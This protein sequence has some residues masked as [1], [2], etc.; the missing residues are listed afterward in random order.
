M[1]EFVSI[2][3]S[4][5]VSLLA[6]RNPAPLPL[7][8][9]APQV[10]GEPRHIPALDG[11]RGIAVLLVLWCHAIGADL[12]T[13]IASPLDRFA[14][15]S[16]RLA[17]SGV[18]LFFVLSG[19]LITGILCDAKGRDHYFRNFY[20]RR[21][22]R[23]FPLYYACLALFLVVIPMLAPA[24]A[25]RFGQPNT[26]QAW[27]WAYLSN[28]SQPFALYLGQPAHHVLS[29]T[30][31]LAVEEQFYLVWPAVVFFLDRRALLRVCGW[32][33]VFSF[34]MRLALWMTLERPDCWQI[35]TDITPC[36]L[37]VLAAG[38]AIA[39]IARGPGGIRGLIKPAKIVGPLAA[40]ILMA[41][42]G[43]MAKLGYRGGLITT[44]GYVLFGGTLYAAMY[45]SLLVWAV[46]QRIQHRRPSVFLR[47]APHVRQ[48]Q[49]RRLP[50]AHAGD[51]A[52]GRVCDA[53]RCAANR[54]HLAAERR[55]LLRDQLNRNA[56]AGMVELERI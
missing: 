30:W 34:G 52:A 43:L 39:L 44:P 24:L 25:Q 36:R 49:L 47:R 15:T 56:G 2:P 41:M 18:D 7:E 37:D 27:Y 38:A 51:H 53:T 11:V 23:I 33:F 22:V 45:G 13:N 21:T 16:A 20:A 50:A 46:R 8:S 19:F 26:S 4:R 40:V 9:R 48:V 17:T 6:D 12:S 55:T 54:R 32:M 35:A 31:S 28:F 3:P 10:R 29:V 14:F 42:V 1:H 5:S